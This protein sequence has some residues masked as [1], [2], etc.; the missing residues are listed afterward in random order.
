MILTF[1]RR[2][3]KATFTCGSSEE[4]ELK[5]NS[6]TLSLWASNS[7]LSSNPLELGCKQFPGLFK[8]NMKY[9]KRSQVQ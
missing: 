3:L 4:M 8:S 5:E 9:I 1:Q 6:L 7:K 2:C